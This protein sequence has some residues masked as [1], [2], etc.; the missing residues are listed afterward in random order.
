RLPPQ[1]LPVLAR[2]VAPRGV[3][4][5]GMLDLDHFGAHVAEV[6]GGH[7]T[8][9]QCGRVDHAQS[10]QRGRHAVASQHTRNP[11]DGDASWPRPGSRNFSA[12]SGSRTPPSTYQ[13]EPVLSCALPPLSITKR[14]RP[15]ECS[16]SVQFHTAGVRLAKP[17]RVAASCHSSSLGRRPPTQA[18][19]ARARSKVTP[20]A[21]RSGSRETTGSPSASR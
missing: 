4:A 5:G 3:G 17:G 7:R 12:N 9:E 19:Y 18:A 21:G 15:S 11:I 20:V 1:V 2:A 14:V 13:S 6:H 16:D 10:V 8:R